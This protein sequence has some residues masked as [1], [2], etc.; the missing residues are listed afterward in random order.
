MG[1]VVYK[2]LSE[3]ILGELLEGKEFFLD[4][5]PL[6]KSSELSLSSTSLSISFLCK[7]RVDVIPFFQEMVCKW[8]VPTKKIFFETFFS[9]RIKEDYLLVEG[10]IPIC[11]EEI[12]EMMERN[13]PVVLEEIRL[14]LVSRYHARSMLE[15]KGLS[16]NEKKGFI[17]DRI[18][19]HFTPP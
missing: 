13:L 9:L 2:S 8:L 6:L 11:S 17:R 14:G 3:K 19:A 18:H 4:T 16:S 7:F 10:V 12:E 1:S 15:I 5:I